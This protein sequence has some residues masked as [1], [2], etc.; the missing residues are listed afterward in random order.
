MDL[1]CR[2]SVPVSVADHVAADPGDRP[3]CV[4]D[5]DAG[6]RDSL[7]VMLETHGFKVLTHASGAELC[8][9]EH[10]RQ[11]AC[12]IV[13][14][15]MPGMDGPDTI[16]VLRRQGIAVPTIL[17]TG[18]LD[19]NVAARAVKL[20][21]IATLEKPFSASRLVDLVRASQRKSDKGTAR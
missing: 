21:V 6:V 10:R 9:D 17:I 20:G 19:P 13:D 3:I 11:I 7:T 18:R 8:A 14:H 2:V 15:H 1:N 16:E 5:D 12:L 4:V